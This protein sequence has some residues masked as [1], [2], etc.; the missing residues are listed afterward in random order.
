MTPRR[1]EAASMLVLVLAW[2]L[3][4]VG[5]FTGSDTL[6]ITAIVLGV[7]GC[8]G[9]CVAGIRDLRSTP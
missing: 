9:H 1:L 7:M 6:V 8:I 4:I 5:L 2:V 3:L